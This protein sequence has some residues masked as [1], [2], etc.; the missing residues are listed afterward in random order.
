M[1]PKAN[2]SVLRVDVHIANSLPTSPSTVRRRRSGLPSGLR[3]SQPGSSL[4]ASR[5]GTTPRP[6][7][8]RLTAIRPWAPQVRISVTSGWP[9]FCIT[10]ETGEWEIVGRPVSLAMATHPQAH[11]PLGGGDAH[12]LGKRRPRAPSLGEALQNR[13]LA[14]HIREPEPDPAV[15]IDPIELNVRRVALR[16]PRIGQVLLRRVRDGACPQEEGKPARPD[17]GRFQ[18]PGEGRAA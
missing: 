9:T 15:E 5:G 7:H 17:D 2:C 4:H 16:P 11:G 3:Q 6:D 1:A 12:G 10:D 18:R 14:P 8:P 13:L